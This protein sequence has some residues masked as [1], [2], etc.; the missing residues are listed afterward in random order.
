MLPQIN[1]I[2]IFFNFKTMK[3]NLLIKHF[4]LLSTLSIA[5]FSCTSYKKISYFKNISSDSAAVF[6]Q[7]EDVAVTPYHALTI[8]PDDILKVTLTTLDTEVNGAA[9]IST[10]SIS[11]TLAAGLP[12]SGK[13]PDGFLVNKEGNIEIPVLGTVQ[14]AGLTI[15]DAQ[16]KILDKAAVL[17]KNPTVNLR[18]TNF[19]VTVLG[20]V[21]K[22]GTYISD[23]EKVSVLDALGLAGDLTIYG[24]R[25]NILLIRQEG[26]NNKKFVRMNLNDTRM[27]ASPYFY[28]KQGDVLY[29]EPTKGK[30]AA[31]DMASTKNYAIAGSVLSLLV[32]LLTRVKL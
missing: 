25:E 32:V 19:K 15:A 13:L 6:T 26:E 4:V 22:P 30:A 5:L 2:N 29:V 10:N 16:K 12:S 24:K 9:N 17:Y 20:E 11:G 1:I 23:G 8:A 3:Q 21:L 14:V 7:G 28:L 18:L 31:T 27:L